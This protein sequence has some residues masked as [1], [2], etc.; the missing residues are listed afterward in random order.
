[1]P[2][3]RRRRSAFRAESRHE[4]AG[5]SAVVEGIGRTPRSIPPRSPRDV[6]Y[7]SWQGSRHWERAPRTRCLERRAGGK[8]AVRL[9]AGGNRNCGTFHAAMST[10][11]MLLPALQIVRYATI[12]RVIPQAHAPEPREQDGDGNVDPVPRR[13][14]RRRHRVAQLV[15]AAT[16]ERADRRAGH[17]RRANRR[18][19]RPEAAGA[20]EGPDVERRRD[21]SRTTSRLRTPRSAI[22]TGTPVSTRRWTARS[23]C[24]PP[25]ASCS[26]SGPSGR[27]GAVT[28][29]RGDLTSATRSSSAAR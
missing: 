15:P 16:D 19:R 3:V 8:A 23:S 21:H 9:L 26:R 20:E 29:R 18:Q 12:R 24:S 14:F 27:I 22:S 13:H 28:T 4:Q 25:K 6:R 2:I 17:A 5:G 1:M 10:I 11:I 7:R